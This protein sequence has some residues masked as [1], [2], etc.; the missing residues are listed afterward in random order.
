MYISTGLFCEENY[1]TDGASDN[2]SALSRLARLRMFS[3]AYAQ[4]KTRLY[5]RQIS[6]PR[7]F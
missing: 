1:L 4:V 2:T 7:L 3:Y 5:L 6:F